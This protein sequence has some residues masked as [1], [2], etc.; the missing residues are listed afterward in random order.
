M[1]DFNSKRKYSN[2]LY[3]AFASLCFVAGLIPLLSI[4]YYTIVNGASA[5]SVDFFTKIT[6]PIGGPGGGILNALIGSLVII[7]IASAIG[8]PIGVLGG[9]FLSEYPGKFSTYVR[10]VA[11]VLTGVPSIVTGIFVYQLIVSATNHFSA[12]SGGVALGFMMVPIVA[13]STHESLKLV[14]ATIREGGLALGLSRAKTLIYILL[15]TARAGVVT[16]IALAVARVMG[17]TAPLLFTALGNQ[18]L[19]HSINDPTSALTILIYDFGTAPYA[20][21][22]VMAWGAALILLFLVLGLNVIVRLASRLKVKGE[23]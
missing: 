22:H 16:G 8:I 17:E 6:P 5:M 15:S 19:M 10:L 7:C 14:P 4:L 13:I 11:E 2:K 9:A 23:V 18:F 20:N 12:W 3:V 1:L 21:A